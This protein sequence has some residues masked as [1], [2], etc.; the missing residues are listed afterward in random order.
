MDITLRGV[1]DEITPLTDAVFTFIF[2]FGAGDETL[3]PG[4]NTPGLDPSPDDL[5]PCEA[6]ACN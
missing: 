5:P 1:R 3:D 2:L 4:P 6:K